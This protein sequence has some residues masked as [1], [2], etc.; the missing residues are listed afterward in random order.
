MIP[1]RRYRDVSPELRTAAVKSV[2]LLQN[3]VS[4]RWR[5]IQLVAEATGVHPNTL[6]NWVEAHPEGPRSP[7]RDLERELRERDAALAA[8][9]EMIADLSSRIRDHA[10]RD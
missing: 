4:S 2:A 8:A 7:R 6:R 10:G 1:Q 3:E 5:A 9:S